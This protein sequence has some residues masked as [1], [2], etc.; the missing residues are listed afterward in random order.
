MKASLE[1]KGIDKLMAKLEKN[2]TLKDVEKVVSVN[3]M[4]LNRKM[5]ENAQFK[6][7]ID[8]KGNFITPTGATRRSITTEK[9]DRGMGTVT[10]PKT[11]YASYLEYGTRFMSA[12]P[13]IKKSFDVQKI[14]FLSDLTR[15]MK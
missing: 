6:G 8:A 11:E 10:F 9:I 14:I 12:Q 15:L 13:F 4:Q 7:H 5:K 1:I 3:G 2:I